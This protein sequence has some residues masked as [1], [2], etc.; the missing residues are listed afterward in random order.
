MANEQLSMFN[1][2]EKEKTSPGRSSGFTI[3]RTVK[4]TPQQVCDQWLIPV[5]L[6]NWM[7]TTDKVI[8]L[9][10]QVRKG[11]SFSY[12]ISHRGKELEYSGEYLVLDI[13]NSIQCSWRRDDQPEAES[14]IT[15]Q[16]TPTGEKTRMLFSM[17]LPAQLEEDKNSLR[18]EWTGRCN[19]LA[20]QLRK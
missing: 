8:E 2:G 3:N 14:L 13:P 11:G 5:F 20:R 9:N 6:E 19:L 12:R 1:E 18:R 10:N 17:K 16:F 4:A 15:L 7:F